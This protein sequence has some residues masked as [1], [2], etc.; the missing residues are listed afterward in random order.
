M[1]DP[2]DCVKRPLA[3]LALAGAVLLAGCSGTIWA[4]DPEPE[5]TLER[6]LP[7][8]V[9]VVLEQQEGRRFR[10]GS[11]VVIAARSAAEGPD[12]FIL[13]SAHTFAGPGRGK[14]VFVLS[15]RHEGPG[16]RTPATVLAV[17]EHEGVDLALLGMRNEDCPVA[18]IGR[19]ARLGESVWVVSFPWGRELTVSRGVISQVRRTGSGPG[20]KVTAGRLMVDAAVSY[21]SSGGGVFRASTGELIGLVEGYPTARVAFE[22]GTS[23]GHV[24]VPVPGQ[25]YLTPIGDAVEFLR[26]SGHGPLV[27]E[28]K[29]D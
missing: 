1:I 8:S 21:G 14:S 25:T 3:L 13:T 11:G 10:S 22:G 19:P 5:L 12:C 4:R 2:V 17:S 24:D 20:H 23:P 18:P 7:S 6:V 16:V 29:P 27:A 28:G 9:Q 26:G 15:Q